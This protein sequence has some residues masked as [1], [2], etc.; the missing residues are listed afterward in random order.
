MAHQGVSE[1]IRDISG[2][3]LLPED[4]VVDIPIANEDAAIEWLRLPENPGNF[5]VRYMTYVA[6][7]WISDPRVAF[8]CKMRFG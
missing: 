1:G 2:I 8:D 6:R 7:V 5:S 3:A 4:Q